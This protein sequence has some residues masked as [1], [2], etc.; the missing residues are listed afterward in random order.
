M[1][2]VQSEVHS[3]GTEMR[4]EMNGQEQMCDAFYKTKSTVTKTVMNVHSDNYR[5][6]EE[7]PNYFVTHT[8]DGDDRCH[9]TSKL[10][11]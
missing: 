9:S 11:R 10:W 2:A 3:H 6:M 7:H 8:V 5:M 4:E 1:L